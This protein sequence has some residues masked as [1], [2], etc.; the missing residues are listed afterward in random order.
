MTSTSTTSTSPPTA[1]WAGWWRPSRRHPWEPLTEG[2][3]YSAALNKLLDFL[4]GEGL[5]GGDVLVLRAGQQPGGA[6][7]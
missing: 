7:A 6:R 5:A 3:D 2:G 1:G 4:Q